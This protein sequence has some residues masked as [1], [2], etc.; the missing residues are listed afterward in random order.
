[1]AQ[2]A[3]LDLVAAFDTSDS[4]TAPDGTAALVGGIA[5]AAAAVS[6]AVVDLCTDILPI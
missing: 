3:D 2:E 4:T 5:A 6:S 1:M